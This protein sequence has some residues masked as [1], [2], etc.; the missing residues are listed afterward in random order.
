MSDSIWRS[1]DTA[2]KSDYGKM[3]CMEM[4]DVA[5][6]GG[7]LC[8]ILCAWFLKDAGVDC[9]LLDK[10][11]I[12]GGTGKDAMAQVTSQHGLIYSKLVERDGVE[13]ARMYFQANELA[14][15]K[16]RELSEQ[17][18]CDFEETS[19]Y[20]YSKNDREKLEKE[21]DA[22][23]R[24]GGKVEFCEATEL[25]F[26]T[27]GAVRFQ[28]QAQLNPVKLMNGL[29]KEL[30]KYQN[31]HVYEGVEIDD[32]FRR[33]IW[34]GMHVTVAD[35]IICTTHTPF[36]EKLGKYN[37]KLHREESCILALRNAQKMN[38]MYT[39]EAQGGL[40]FRS[41]GDLLLMT[42]G[43]YKTESGR[44]VQEWEKLRKAAAMYHPEAKE[45]ANWKV[46]DCF[47]LDGIPYIGS[48]ASK[49]KTPGLYVATGFNGWGMTSAMTAAMLLT[50]T[51]LKDK[52]GEAREAVNYP[53]KEVF[54]PE[55]RILLPQY[56]SNI[57]DTISD[58]FSSRS[59]KYK[60]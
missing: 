28:G 56:F 18:N 37:R 51:I 32:W 25:P 58:R 29:V 55:R 35:H 12:A 50:E 59:Q 39:D 22:V 42:G 1:I 3:E 17:I 15:Q 14:I 54:S 23:S 19:S 10:N 34:C 33:A 36:Y 2:E 45:M 47:S 13:K 30:E 11:R 9:I 8:G 53:W 26:A 20:V 5:I 40:S 27:S 41:Y 48:Y 57:K 6:V 38:G 16:Y 60:K 46:Q 43:T 7:G 31:I 44:E 49:R 24:I 52:F 4:T 21:I